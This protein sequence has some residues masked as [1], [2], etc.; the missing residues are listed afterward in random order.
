[1][2]E[3]ARNIGPEWPAIAWGLGLLAAAL[4]V[5]MMVIG[6]R[7]PK[8]MRILVLGMDRDPTPGV[9]LYQSFPWQM[10]DVMLV[11]EYHRNESQVIFR[12]VPR[13]TLAVISDGL[14]WSKIG[15]STAEIGA[16]KTCGVVGGLLG[17]QIDHYVVLT[18]PDLIRFFGIVGGDL[19]PSQGEST[20]RPRLLQELQAK[21]SGMQADA[22]NTVRLIL[23]RQGSDTQRQ[24]EQQAFIAQFLA[25]HKRPN[26]ICLA[27]LA[28]W[29]WSL[30]TDMSVINAAAFA[31][32]VL[33]CKY[34]F[35]TLPTV[36]IYLNGISYILPR[37]KSDQGHQP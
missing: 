11:V 18:I 28:L 34:Q 26:A 27:R 36:P 1:M 23:Q 22:L 15:T 20:E 21:F 16:K 33:S 8:A 7:M 37:N 25:D 17:C 3:V 6:L 14:G 29:F 13:D 5:S 35:T 31:K 12:Q 30:G 9:E 4:L 19:S 10:S 24:G 32:Q 2:S